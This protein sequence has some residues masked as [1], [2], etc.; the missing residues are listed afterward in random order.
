ML[1]I[2]AVIGSLYLLIQDRNEEAVAQARR[3]ISA[4][5]KKVGTSAE[6]WRLRLH[7]AH[8]VRSA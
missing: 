5:A 8:H 1:L 2:T 3:E 7:G 4:T 6:K